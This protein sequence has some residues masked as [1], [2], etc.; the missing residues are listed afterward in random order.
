[1][2]GSAQSSNGEVIDSFS[3]WIAVSRPSRV[4]PTAI[5]CSCSSRWPAEV[6]ICGRVRLSFTGRPTCRAAIAASV[7]CGQTIAL[8][9]NPPPTKWVTTRRSDSGIP[10]SCAT[11]SW[12]ARMPCVD[13]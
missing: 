10:S 8:H 5:R 7:E 4:A 6:Y 9:P 12:L 11:V 1:V 2:A 3:W 13:S